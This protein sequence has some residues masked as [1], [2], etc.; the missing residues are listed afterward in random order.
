L[1]LF[2]LKA[3]MAI[4]LALPANKG[5]NCFRPKEAAIE[6][7]RDLEQFVEYG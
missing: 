7:W 4:S 3:F 2:S 5:W 1:A 6:L